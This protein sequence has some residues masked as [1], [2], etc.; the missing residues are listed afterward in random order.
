M[1]SVNVPELIEAGVITCAADLHDPI[2]GLDAGCYMV[3]KAI[4]KFGV[5]ENAY[6]HYNAGLWAKGK[7][8]KNSRNMWAEYQRFYKVLA[9]E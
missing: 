2:K 4:R 3:D 7:S 8:N 5:T 1:N 6:F 9:D